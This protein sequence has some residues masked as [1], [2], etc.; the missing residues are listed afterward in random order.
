MSNEYVCTFTA[1]PKAYFCAAHSSSL[2]QLPPASDGSVRKCLACQ[3]ARTCPSVTAPCPDALPHL[4][5]SGK[6]QTRGNIQSLQSLS[7][8]STLRWPTCQERGPWA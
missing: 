1:S 8:G 6:I 5:S 2:P 4:S 3:W 7:S